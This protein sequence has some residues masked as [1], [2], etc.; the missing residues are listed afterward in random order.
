MLRRDKAL[1]ENL[2]RKYN[3]KT[4]ISNIKE[5][6]EDTT[7]VDIVDYDYIKGKDFEI[8]SIDIPN[9]TGDVYDMIDKL[10]N[11]Q[12]FKYRN[13]TY[14][15]KDNGRVYQCYRDDTNNCWEI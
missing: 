8:V 14:I 11:G 2:I 3:K 7:F 4:I 1:L 9:W 12:A 15:F 13:Y 6:Y 10:K 5:S